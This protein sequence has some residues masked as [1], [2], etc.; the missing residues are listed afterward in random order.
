MRFVILLPF[1]PSGLLIPFFW[2]SGLRAVIRREPA[3]LS[4]GGQLLRGVIAALVY[5]YP[6]VW[7][8]ALVLTVLALKRK[9][10][11]R[12]LVQLAV[13]PF[14]AAALPFILADFLR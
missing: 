13:A 7:L 14:A 2:Q 12:K 11:D 8:A 5:G 4:M 3:E 9:E 1:F 6:L 10:S